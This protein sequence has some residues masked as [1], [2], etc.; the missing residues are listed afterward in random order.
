M[1][2][3][4]KRWKKAGKQTAG[5]TKDKHRKET[6]IDKGM[7]RFFVGGESK[8]AG[9]M[10]YKPPRWTAEYEKM[11][12]SDLVRRIQDDLG[13][14]QARAYPTYNDEWQQ[15]FAPNYWQEFPITY[16]GRLRTEIH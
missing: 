12:V 9:F 11:R 10:H 3:N 13:E 1:A 8:I 6:G 15:Q 14:L 4:P 7:D 2:R 16:E 5:G